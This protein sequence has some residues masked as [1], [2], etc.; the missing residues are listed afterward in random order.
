MRDVTQP[1]RGGGA[2]VE[3]RRVSW[4]CVAAFAISSS[5]AV[6]QSGSPDALVQSLVTTAQKNFWGRAVLSKGET[7]Q[8]VDDAERTAPVIPFVDSARVVNAAIPVGRAL[9][10]GVEWQPYYL[11]FM[12]AERRGSW[13][14]KQIAFIG[15]LFG[16]TQGTVSTA[17]TQRGPCAAE[18]RDKVVEGIGAATKT[19]QAPA[20]DVR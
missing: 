4:S 14:E 10:C 5:L 3:L 6:A 13:S 16:L 12:Q 8:P 17:L 15:V 9:W 2:A 19:L 1:L 11:A 7:V 18:T 20:E